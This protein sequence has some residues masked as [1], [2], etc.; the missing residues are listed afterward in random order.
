MI[1]DE[2]IKKDI[3][4]HLYW[5]RRVDAADVKV[6]VSEGKVGLSG[7]VPSLTTALAAEED[8]YGVEGVTFVENEL[9]VRHSAAADVPSDKEL[10]KNIEMVLKWN[11][12][13]ESPDVH[14]AVA[15]GHVDLEGTVDNYWK[16]VRVEDT[17]SPLKGVVRVTNKLAVVPTEDVNDKMLAEDIV[18]GLDRNLL[19][20][21]EDLLVEVEEG[22]VRLTGIVPDRAAL[23]AARDTV[24]RTAGVRDIRN[25]LIIR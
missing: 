18:T 3:V 21:A 5:D 24:I 13:L 15:E 16:K 19:V 14:V 4:D 23:I 7:T 1:R 22:R 11:A 17:I 25:E 10:K 6:E 2:K 12:D 9:S 20:N 8:C